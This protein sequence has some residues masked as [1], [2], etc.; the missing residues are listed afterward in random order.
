MTAADVKI[1]GI[2]EAEHA[3]TAAQAGARWLGFVFFP[4]SPRNLTE[5]AAK[6][7][8]PLLPKGPKRVGV[9]VNADD[10]LLDMA[11]NALKLD[12]VQ[13]H[14]SETPEEATRIKNKYGVRIIKALGVSTEADLRKA[15]AFTGIADRILFDAKPPKDAVLPGGN[16][17][18]FPWH[19]LKDK[20]LPYPWMLAG[21]L[22][23]ENATQAIAE[24]GTQALDIS[25][26]VE[27]SPGK[28]SNVMIKAFLHA[29]KSAK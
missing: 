12:A 19:I 27:T 24:S 26:G 16:A 14:G 1:C 28:K 21:G 11:I 20:D 18:S 6:E 23:A 17:V 7:L 22:T 15:D 8:G 3:H 2:T 4:K 29:A 10:A 13:L 9:F 25:S 5:K